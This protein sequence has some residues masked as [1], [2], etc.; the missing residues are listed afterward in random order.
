MT[1]SP[2]SGFHVKVTQGYKGGSST[3][4]I[5]RRDPNGNI[6]QADFQVQSS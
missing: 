4:I 5:I 6:S 2:T 1:G 3:D